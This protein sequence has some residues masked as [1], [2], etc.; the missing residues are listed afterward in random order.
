MRSKR[1]PVLVIMVGCWLAGGTALAAPRPT[2]TPTPTPLP[3]RGVNVRVI[4]LQR[5]RVAPNTHVE[6]P[7]FDQASP[8]PSPRR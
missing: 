5:Y 4:P 7:P 2:P 3:I 8:S 6:R 1:I